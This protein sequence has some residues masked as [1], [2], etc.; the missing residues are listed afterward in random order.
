[1]ND[2]EIYYTDEDGLSD[3]SGYRVCYK[4]LAEI[5]TDGECISTSVYCEEVDAFTFGGMKLD[6]ESIEKIVAPAILQ[7]INDA[8]IQLINK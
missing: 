3:K 2:D 8:L 1:M 7:S 6:N 5:K 4:L